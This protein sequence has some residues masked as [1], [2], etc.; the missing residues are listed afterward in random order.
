MAKDFTLEQL[1][2]SKNWKMLG[3]FLNYCL[4]HPEYRF[5]QALRNW[6]REYIDPDINFIIAAPMGW[7]DNPEVS[8]DTFYWENNK[9]HDSRDTVLESQ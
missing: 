3:S 1:K 5:W 8:E 7:L 9:F 2:K 4:D 6:A